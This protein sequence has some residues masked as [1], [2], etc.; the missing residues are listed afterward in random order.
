MPK[1]RTNDLIR[2]ARHGSS[3]ALE[4]LLVRFRS[5]IKLLARIQLDRHL[6]SKVDPSDLVQETWLESYRAFGTFQGHT[7]QEFVA[8]QRQILTTNIIDCFRHYYGA[9]KRDVRLERSLQ[10]AME[11]SSLLLGNLLID[12]ATSPSQAAGQHEQSVLLADALEQLTDDYRDVLIYRHLEGLSFKDVASRMDRSLNSVEKLW[13]RALG[14]LR[15]QLTK[16][17]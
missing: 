9:Q 1:T 7:E 17:Q 14:E 5:Y 2:Q 6:S 12:E 15:S 4:Q 10:E 11:Y 8:W 3:E 13:M 16:N